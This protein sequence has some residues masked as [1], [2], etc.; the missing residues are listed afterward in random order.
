MSIVVYTHAPTVQ[1]HWNKNIFV[2]WIAT[3]KVGVKSSGQDQKKATMKK[4]WNQIGRPRPTAFDNDDKA[5]EHFERKECFAAC[6]Y[7]QKF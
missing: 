1:I 7:Y 6:H 4:I 3:K 2:I 5:A